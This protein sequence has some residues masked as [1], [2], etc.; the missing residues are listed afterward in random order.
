MSYYGKCQIPER[1]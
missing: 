1:V